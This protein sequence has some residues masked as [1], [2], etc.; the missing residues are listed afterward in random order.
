MVQ[1]S[2]KLEIMNPFYCFH[3][4]LDVFSVIFAFFRSA[5]SKSSSSSTSISSSETSMTSSCVFLSSTFFDPLTTIFS[6]SSFKLTFM[7]FMSTHAGISTVFDHSCVELSPK[8]PIFCSV[9]D[10]PLRI[11]FESLMLTFK[12]SAF[13]GRSDKPIVSL[14]LFDFS[15]GIHFFRWHFPRQI[16]V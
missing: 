5:A 15:T 14:H 13:V 11:S 4:H 10:V 7:V 2:Y 12:S 6:L 8:P 3:H 9:R 16:G 1:V